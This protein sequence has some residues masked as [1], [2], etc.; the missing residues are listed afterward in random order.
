MLRIM[1]PYN[2][3]YYVYEDESEQNEFRIIKA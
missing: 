1:Q 3:T 2:F